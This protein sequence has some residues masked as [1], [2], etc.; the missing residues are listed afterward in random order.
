MKHKLESWLPV[1]ISVATDMQMKPL[2]WQKA[3]KN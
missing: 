2:L 1:E 3:K